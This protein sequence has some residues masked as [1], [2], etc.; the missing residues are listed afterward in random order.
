[1]D[2]VTILVPKGRKLGF[3]EHMLVSPGEHFEFL[4]LIKTFDM[5][6][7]IMVQI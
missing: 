6:D 5:V 2:V 4:Q 3:R 7:R 1:M